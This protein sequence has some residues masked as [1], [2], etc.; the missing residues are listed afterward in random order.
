MSF[1]QPWWLAGAALAA[2]A[3]ALLAIAGERVQRRAA[4]AYS[5]VAF[6]DAALGKPFPWASA[7]A[8]VWAAAI[9]L[10]GAALARPTI[11]ADVP[12]ADGA[13]VLCIDTSGSMAS[14][15]VAPTRSGAARAAVRAFLDAVPA[16]TRIGFVGFSSSAV[17]LGPLVD[18]RAAARDELDR[19]PAPNG[20]TA[21]GGALE[22]AARMLPP[23]G[24]R[25]IVLVTDGVN[26]RGPD[27]LEAARRVA[28]AGIAIF[29]VGI[30]TNGSDAVVPGTAETAELDEAALREIAETG[31]GSYART[32]DATALLARLSG[33][34]QTA[35][36]ERRRLELGWA[37]ALTGG[38]LAFGAAFGGVA[39][40][41]FP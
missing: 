23:A 5:S 28:A 9:V 14:S 8:A 41:R 1:A 39:L 37:F 38:L 25:A 40:G 29:T 3:F 36:K 20:A 21:I 33:L 19:L 27:P 24:R 2:A 15:D 30:G 18:E 22:A 7:F 6:L 13:V 32:A 11:V 17:P 10:A 4:L 12:V 35:V 34:A 31:H 26:N 16:G